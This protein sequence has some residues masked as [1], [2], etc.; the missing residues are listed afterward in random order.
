MRIA[1]AV[2]IGVW[3]L[4]AWGG[5]IGLLTSGEGWGAWLRIGGSLAVGLVAVLSLTVPALEGWRKPALV[6]FAI[7][8]IVLWVRSLI[9][10][11]TGSGSL[12]FKLVHT[13]LAVGFF[14]LAW[15]ALSMTSSSA[16]PTAAARDDAHGSQPGSDETGSEAVGVIES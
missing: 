7:F 3:T 4:A 6:T 15:W 2:A 8:T 10:T 16:S 5:R 1:L 11:W 12:P 13:V 9:V 14:A